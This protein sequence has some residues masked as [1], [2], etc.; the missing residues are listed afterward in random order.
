M[1][2]SLHAGRFPARSAAHCAPGRSFRL[3]RLAL[4]LALPLAVI[5]SQALS[6]PAHA[7]VWG[8]IDEAGRSHVATEKL[9]DRYTLFF[10]G[11]VRIDQPQ[12]A[13]V[14]DNA[15]ATALVEP[16][17]S[18]A[19]ARNAARFD[20]MIKQYAAMHNV[21]PALVK[22]VIAV[23]SAFQPGVVSAKGA[24]GLMQIIP[25]TGER[26][27]VVADRKKSVAEKLSDPAT[28]LRVGTRYLRDLLGMFAQNVELAL[29]AY[30]A[31]ENAVQRHKNTV[32]PFPETREYVKR[33]QKLYANF[34]PPKPAA[35]M[36]LLGAAQVRF[37]IPGQRSASG[38]I[39]ASLSTPPLTP[40][41]VP[42]P[43]PVGLAPRSTASLL[44]PTSASANTVTAT[45]DPAT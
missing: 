12:P 9:D 43:A 29:A 25:G 34:R 22:A 6:T 37:V 31:G 41:L 13:L 28:N 16:Q 33:V 11:G 3:S 21:D 17:P 40:P 35:A 5:F 38:I 2:R 36:P 45:I 24:L 26:Y 30:N 1:R 20:P 14:E 4:P 27:G 10:K 23:E 18:V 44:T 8:Y 39:P 32:P 19:A 42:T 15:A 7:D